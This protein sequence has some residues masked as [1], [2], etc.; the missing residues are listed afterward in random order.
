MQLTL[1]E[2]VA[3]PAARP[4]WITVPSSSSM[5]SCATPARR[6]LC[7]PACRSLHTVSEVLGHSSMAMTRRYAHL[8]PQHLT[9]AIRKLA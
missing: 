2:A 1:T 9:D 3:V 7:R 5:R 6:G 8:A 4:S